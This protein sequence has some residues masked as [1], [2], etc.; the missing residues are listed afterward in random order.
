MSESPFVGPVADLVD[1]YF[2][3]EVKKVGGVRA[4][5][6]ARNAAVY[7][8][9]QNPGRWAQVGEGTTGL[10]KDMLAKICPDLQVT[11]TGTMDNYRGRRTYA[12]VPHPEGET[13]GKA[14]KRRPVR[15]VPIAKLYLPELTRDEFNWTRDELEDACRIAR[16]NLFP[17]GADD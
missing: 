10:T 2:T 7:W 17:T 6:N 4:A 9:R 15:Q 13:L 14:L 12:R 3:N 11:E 16:A 5:T 8:M 1:P